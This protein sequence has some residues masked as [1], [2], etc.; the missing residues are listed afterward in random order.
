MSKV[1]IRARSR[2]G[3][4]QIEHSFEEGIY[5]VGREAGDLVLGDP[6]ISG[7]HGTLT[8]ANG[9]AIYT[10]TGSTNGSFDES[11]TRLPGPVD[12]LA[13]PGVW[14]AQVHLSA[15]AAPTVSSKSGT[16]VLPQMSWPGGAPGAPAGQ[17]QSLQDP[18]RSPQLG[19][20]SAGPSGKPAQKSSQS[21]ADGGKAAL[22]EEQR[23]KYQ[24][25]YNDTVEQLSD[26]S[27]READFTGA[28][29][30]ARK[31]LKELSRSLAPRVTQGL[32]VDL[33]PPADIAIK[34]FTLG[35]VWRGI[36]H[37]S[38]FIKILLVLLLLG[39]VGELIRVEVGG[40]LLAY[41]PLVGI[42]FFMERRYRLKKALESLPTLKK[43]AKASSI[44]YL[45]QNQSA[46]SSSILGYRLEAKSKVVADVELFQLPE[47]DLEPG[48]LLLEID[49]LGSW[50]VL[51][52]RMH[53][54]HQDTENA[55]LEQLLPRISTVLD[56]SGSKLRAHLPQLS[57]YGALRHQRTRASDDVPRVEQLLHQAD[58]LESV[59]AHTYAPAEVLEPL[60]RR[61]DLFNMRDPSTPAGILLYGMPGNGKA[62][63]AE[64]VAASVKARLEAI[65]PSM[66]DDRGD[67]KAL[68]EQARHRGPTVF[69]VDHAERIFPP[70][71]NE[72][73]AQA[74]R[75]EWSQASASES[76]VWVIMATEDPE[77]LHPALL[78]QF[79][80]SKI[81]VPA[82]NQ[83]C[84]TEILKKAFEDRRLGDPP[85]WLVEATSGASVAELYEIATET[86][87]LCTP[88]PPT[89]AEIRKALEAVRGTDAS[90]KDE[91]RTWDR[92]VLPDAIKVQLKSAAQILS[93]ADRYQQQGISVPNILLY[94][95]PG[96]G[97]TEI[98]RTLANECGV[99]FFAAATADLKGK[100][101]GESAQKVRAVFEKA[102]AAAP[103]VLFIDEIENVAGKRDGGG[104]SFNQDIVNEML[105]QMDG[106]A[107]KKGQL[108]V[109]AA[110][111][112]P[113]MIDPAILSRFGKPI[114]I[115]LPDL[116]CRTQMLMRFIAERPCDPTMDVAE[117]SQELARRTEHRSGRDLNKLI[118]AAIQESVM[119]APSPDWVRLTR[120]G[121]LAQVTPK[122]ANISDDR[123]QEIWSR[124]VLPEA[125]K[126]SILAKVRM[127]NKG[128]R[129]APRGLLLCGP[130]GTGK[131]EIARRIS[132]SVGSHFLALTNADLKQ[133]FLGQSGQAAKKV[134]DQARAKGRCVIFVDECDGVF[135]KRDSVEGDKLTGEV[136]AEF[137][138]GWDGMK[139]GGQVWVIGATNHPDRID[140]AI[141]S[142]FGTSV[143]IALP[144]GP[145]RAQI[146]RLEM[147]KLERPNV[148]IP[149]FVVHDTTGFAGRDLAR[150]AADVCT[151]AAE[152]DRDPNESDF[153]SAL[154]KRA[155]ASSAKV[156]SSATWDS[157]ILDP[158]AI[159]TFKTLCGSLQHI[160]VLRAQGIDPPRA[161]LLYGPPGTGKT[162]IARTLANESG[163]AFVAAS[164]ADLKAGYI[165]QSG[166]KVQAL[167]R[168]AREKAPA[169]LFIDEIDAA[170][171]QRG[172][173]SGDSFTDEVINTLLTELDGVVKHDR[174]VFVLAATNR[175]ELIDSAIRSRFMEEIEIP[176]PDLAQ[177]IQLFKLLIE[178]KRTNFDASDQA[179]QL[180]RTFGSLSGR[181]IRSVVERA[182]QSALTRALR[183][184]T[185]DQVIL[186][187]EDFSSQL[188][189]PAPT[190]GAAP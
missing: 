127:F 141:S 125:T 84:R 108:F 116:E 117:V 154:A 67:I 91:K 28:L 136:V 59:W 177:R 51:E 21:A 41:L 185:P 15:V 164:P 30:D 157:L 121:L 139:A 25:H 63:L 24:A 135:T 105:T 171:P 11:G 162:Q 146:L 35:P 75:V 160:E 140:S 44:T 73:E 119:T 49:G 96:T 20:T 61:I 5:Q 187:V 167:F 170:T 37:G 47:L 17:L 163:L 10:D 144:G 176:L 32:K 71:Q 13:S 34:A 50:K 60:L 83:N 65:E 26:S 8:I 22:F 114:E 161:A 101:I 82:P 81:N 97:K 172:N 106:V 159:E 42:C 85:V 130:P 14:A 76:H 48:G 168:S 66:L 64:R 1:T 142:R 188:P 79:A 174:H 184:G 107:K 178:K 137:L 158:A 189:R 31:T 94:G 166:L 46:R 55:A 98:G 7:A 102:R 23:N 145:E 175:P 179:E 58:R 131:T 56:E 4:I 88:R 45:F 134:W 19:S 181:D 112:L 152:Q 90:I 122:A 149:D 147:E 169:I 128:D 151:L 80:S 68:W 27:A 118:D 40:F 72:K 138:A 74:W 110:T 143:E 29:E 156:D 12:L 183:Q 2:D 6:S 77:Q 173:R 36:K 100:F 39:L 3:Q 70:D 103:A 153:R 111:N 89:E 129:A 99:Q 93:Q 16:Q 92:L 115:P 123:L 165:G 104:D 155:S 182:A 78:R 126:S 18:S 38:P 33:A 43:L 186:Q 180:A 87:L 133:G 54:I 148:K 132:D 69:F 190:A 109:L 86:R 113:D 124:I 120:E 53:L 9:K 62:H 95:P 52:R 150:L 57:A